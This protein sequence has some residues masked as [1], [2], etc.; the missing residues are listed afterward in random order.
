MFAK[1]FIIMANAN[2]VRHNL[3]FDTHIVYLDNIFKTRIILLCT[4][5]LYIHFRSESKPW[6]AFV[7]VRSSSYTVVSSCTCVIYANC[8]Y[9]YRF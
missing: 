7:C 4:R 9:P 5:E 3:N 8:S 6:S 2:L 1:I